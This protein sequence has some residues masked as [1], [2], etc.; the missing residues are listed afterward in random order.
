[1]KK[2]LPILAAVV[3]AAILLADVGHSQ[4]T[5]D[6]CALSNH[7]T[8]SCSFYLLMCRSENCGVNGPDEWAGC[9]NCD[10]Y[11]DS[12][13]NDCQVQCGFRQN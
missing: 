1:M 2:R 11:Y 7:C 4:E 6:Y 10:Y 13:V 3:V 5:T 8:N 9:R 12:C